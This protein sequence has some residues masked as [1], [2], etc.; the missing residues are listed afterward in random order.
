MAIDRTGW[1][2]GASKNQR[3]PK[4]NSSNLDDLIDNGFE[5]KYDDDDFM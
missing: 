2:S 5:D 4:D 3:D 1:A